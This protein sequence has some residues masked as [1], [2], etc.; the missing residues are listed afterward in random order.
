MNLRDYAMQTG[1]NKPS[2]TFT[3]TD[4]CAQSE[5]NAFGVKLWEHVQRQNVTF[6]SPNNQARVNWT[7]LVGT[8]TF[9]P[10]WNLHSTTGLFVNPGTGIWSSNLFMNSTARFQLVVLGV[11]LE[12]QTSAIV[13]NVVNGG[14][15]SCQY[16]LT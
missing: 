8:Q 4:I 10:G 9:I 5:Q 16:T 11:I 1:F 2:L 13:Y 14:V 15:G 7:D 12:D 3:V 6:G